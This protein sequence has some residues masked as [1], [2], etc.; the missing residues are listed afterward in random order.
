MLVTPR[1]I[2]NYAP[3]LWCAYTE[4]LISQ[5]LSDGTMKLE[6]IMALL[7]EVVRRVVES[8]K[9]RL[10][11]TTQHM[12]CA[13]QEAGCPAYPEAREQRRSSCG[14]WALRCAR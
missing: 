2:D 5:K 9:L 14:I 4:H 8:Y 3:H 13:E 1:A 12:L 10:S 6:E 11:L 7:P